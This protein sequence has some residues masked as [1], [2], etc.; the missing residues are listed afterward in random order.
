MN[1]G[2][3]KL[4]EGE[5]ED[6]P[7]DA[8][9]KTQCSTEIDQCATVLTLLTVG[10]IPGTQPKWAEISVKSLSSMSSPSRPIT[11]AMNDRVNPETPFSI[12]DHGTSGLKAKVSRACYFS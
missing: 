8:Y 11:E 5:I 2:K 7:G 6:T 4:R 9:G 1:K 10:C 12:K 3:Q